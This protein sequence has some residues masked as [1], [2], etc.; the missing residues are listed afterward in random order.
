[1]RKSKKDYNVKQ[2]NNK[3]NSKFTISANNDQWP[4]TN[5][6]PPVLEIFEIQGDGLA[7]VYDGFVVGTEP[8]KAMPVP[9]Q[10]TPATPASIWSVS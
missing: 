9:R 4:T 5:I 1:M 2:Y 8:G 6:P 10:A 3:S 7:S